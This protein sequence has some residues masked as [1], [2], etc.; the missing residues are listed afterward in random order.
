[1][2]SHDSASCSGDCDY[3]ERRAEERKEDAMGDPGYADDY[4]DNKY[5][6]EMERSWP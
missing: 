1:M 5:E 4:M 3:C 6:R 2:R